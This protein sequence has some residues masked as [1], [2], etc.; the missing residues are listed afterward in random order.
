MKY[1]K[2]HLIYF[3]AT[4]TTAKITQELLLGLGVATTQCHNIT[5]GCPESVVVASDE[6]AIFGVPVYSGRVPQIA[7]EN[8]KKFSAS[9]APAIIVCVYGNREFDDALIE[10]YDTISGN[11]FQIVSAAAFIAQHSIFPEVAHG[12]PDA[13]DMALVRE[14]AR[15]SMELLNRTE[16]SELSE[17]TVSG[18]RPYRPIASIPLHPSTDK[19]CNSC[20]LCARGCPAQAIDHNKPSKIETT[21]CISC[22]HCIAICPRKAKHFSGVLYWLVSRKFTKNYSAP[23][24]PYMIYATEK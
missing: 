13:N 23:K 10:M 11:N 9:G 4:G 22:A 21:K 3:G 15:R 12:R 6:I 14:F 18:N 16:L 8:L 20:Q 19:R 17:L 2:A 7:V 24:E 1:N 5:K